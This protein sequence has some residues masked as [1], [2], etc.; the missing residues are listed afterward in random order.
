MKTR[1]SVAWN[2]W[3]GSPVPHSKTVFEQFN[4]YTEEGAPTDKQIKKFA[5]GQLGYPETLVIT[6]RWE[7]VDESL[8]PIGEAEVA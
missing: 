6:G 4:Y 7:V 1:V 5:T 3:V 2:E 8:Q